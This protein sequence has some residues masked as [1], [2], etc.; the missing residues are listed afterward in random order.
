ML[1]RLLDAIRHRGEIGRLDLLV[2]LVGL[3]AAVAVVTVLWTFFLR[4][5]DDLRVIDDLG[6][7]HRVAKTIFSI[8][9]WSVIALLAAGRLRRLGWPTWLAWLPVINV[10][11]GTPLLLGYQIVAGDY[12]YIPLWIMLIGSISAALTLILIL[13]ALVWDRSVS[14]HLPLRHRAILLVSGFVVLSLIVALKGS[15]YQAS[16]EG[17]MF[18]PTL[19]KAVLPLVQFTPYFLIGTVPAIVVL[20]SKDLAVHQV[21]LALSISG[22]VFVVFVVWLWI[23]WL[24]VAVPFNKLNAVV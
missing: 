2:A 6:V 11:L 3:F 21:R 18:L 17:M 7:V 4:T 12:T 13:S 23:L 14:N 19:T 8:V 24:A 9:A 1:T 15:V 22:A 5:I 10:L 20:A 16:L